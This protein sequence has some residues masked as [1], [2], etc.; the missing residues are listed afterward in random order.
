V[1]ILVLMSPN[2]PGVPGKGRM[3]RL[4]VGSAGAGS[5]AFLRVAR[6]GPL[7]RAGIRTVGREATA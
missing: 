5:A 7:G 1:S 6:W 4:G 3:A 2:T